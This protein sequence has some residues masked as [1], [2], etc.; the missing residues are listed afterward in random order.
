MSIIGPSSP[1]SGGPRLATYGEEMTSPDDRWRPAGGHGPDDRDIVESDPRAWTPRQRQLGI[2]VLVVAALV[3]GLAGGYAAGSR[4]PAAAPAPARSAPA[5]GV[6]S[7]GPNAGSAALTI[8]G[9]VAG[10]QGALCSLQSG[11]ELQLGVEITNQSA[12]A[13]VL[14][15][16]RA[17]LP[18]G[19]LQ[20][21][22]ETWGPC[23]ELPIAANGGNLRPAGQ[24]VLAG[25][26]TAWF[27]VTFKVLVPCPQ[28]SPVQFAVTF[29]PQHPPAGAPGFVVTSQLPGFV[30]LG[31]VPYSGCPLVN[32][33]PQYVP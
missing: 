3:A 30:D 1:T 5:A 6:T 26:G 19:G 27:T 24:N 22:A 29:T 8:T 32:P 21:I 17:E 4:S 9:G 18:L 13:L 11:H 33:N 16:V 14:K 15:K 31:A 10:A 20:A 25:G 12:Q 7:A 2:V 23:G 28:A